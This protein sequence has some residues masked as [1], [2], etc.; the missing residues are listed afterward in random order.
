MIVVTISFHHQRT[1][2][3]SKILLQSTFTYLC[4]GKGKN[5]DE[6]QHGAGLVMLAVSLTRLLTV[7]TVVKFYRVHTTRLLSNQVSVGGPTPTQASRIL[8]T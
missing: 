6:E 2:E 5:G 7:P 4:K 1:D 8:L 3:E